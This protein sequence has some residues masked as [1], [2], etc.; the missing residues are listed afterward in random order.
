MVKRRRG[1]NILFP[2][3]VRH[4]ILPVR[5]QLDFHKKTPIRSQ[6]TLWERIKTHRAAKLAGMLVTFFST[7]LAIC[8]AVSDVFRGPEIQHSTAQIDDP[9]LVLFSLHNPSA[10]FTM[11][12]IRMN[13]VL[14]RIELENNLSLVE[15]PVNDGIVTNIQPDKTI[16]YECPIYKAIDLGF[17]VHAKIKINVKFRTLGH[18]RSTESELFN[19]DITS[20]QWIK[21]EIIN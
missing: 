3:K 1:R 15:I 18:E 8:F 16:Q 11:T 17:I 2:K 4:K 9:F 14:E 6:Q 21:G 20:R 13:C 10:I 5:T 7:T 19:W 12:D